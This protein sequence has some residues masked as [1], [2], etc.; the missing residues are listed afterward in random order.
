MKMIT[1]GFMVLAI[2]FLS[3]AE[4]EA[5][6][7]PIG[8]PHTVGGMEIA[9]VYL[10]P[11]EMEPGEGPHAMRLR[12]DSDIH[13]EADISAAE[14]NTNGFAV[15]EWVPYLSI[16]YTLIK[17]KTGEKIEGKMTAMVANDGPH[18]GDNVK[19]LGVG[20]YKLVVRVDNPLVVGFGRHT[21]KETGVGAWFEPV[22]VE[23][24]FNYLGVGKKG[25]Y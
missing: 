13:L 20:K 18:Y 23:W 14:G 11:I 6:E 10:Q 22:T 3:C 2:L 15:G 24:E 4:A 19:M 9:A 5:A 8:L 21:D 17:L 1:K 25:G 7:K 16:D 12:K